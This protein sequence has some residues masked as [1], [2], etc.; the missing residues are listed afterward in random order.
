[1]PKCGRTVGT[2]RCRLLSVF[3]HFRVLGFWFPPCRVIG[4]RDVLGYTQ[5]LIRE[6]VRELGELDRRR[7]ALPPGDY[8]SCRRALLRAIE[9]LRRL[10]PIIEAEF[11]SARPT[12]TSCLRKPCAGGESIRAA[13]K[14]SC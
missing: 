5:S 13:R 3:K 2:F 8:L 10:L 4:M 14:T 6:R 11:G 7:T 1:V 12:D 9:E